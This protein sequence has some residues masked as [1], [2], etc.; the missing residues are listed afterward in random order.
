[1]LPIATTTITI[2]DVDGTGDPY[3]PATPT[4]LATG[5]PAH[6]SAP[7][8]ADMAIGGDKETVTAVLLCDRMPTLEHHHR[9]VDDATGD[10]YAVVWALPRRGFGLDHQR[11]GV[12]LVKGAADG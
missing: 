5:V 6:F 11:A 8:G 12:R 4:T 1:M 2:V 9:V 3:E 7:N 10:E